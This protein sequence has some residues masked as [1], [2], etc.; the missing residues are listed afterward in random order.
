MGVKID[1]VPHYVMIHDEGLRNAALNLSA[2]SMGPILQALN[3]TTRFMSFVNT[4]AN[5]EFVMGNF[6][7]DIQTAIYNI[8]GEQTMEGGKATLAKGIIS[9]VIRKTPSSI[10]VMYKGLRDP[11]KL[12]GE[13]KKN[14]DEFIGSGAKTDWFHSPAPEEAKANLQNM[15]EMSQGTFK[16]NT[17]AAFGSVL[18][19]VEN[20][21]SAVENGVRFSTFVAARDAMIEKG[22]P[23]SEAIQAAS[24]LAKNLTVNFNRKG[25]AGNLLNGLFLFFN[26]SVQG[27]MNM[28][29]GLNPL[30]PRS[31]RLK[32]GM[33]GGIVGFGA[34]MA[35]IADELLDEEDLEL[36]DAEGYIRDRNMIIPKVLFGVNPEEGKVP[37]WKIPLPYGYNFFHVMGELAYQ[38]ANDNVSPEKAAIRL[39]N[40]GLGSFNPLGTSSSETMFGS[41]AKTI[42]PTIAKPVTEIAM[43]ENYFSSPIY[44]ADSPFGNVADPSMSNRK[45]GGTAEAWRYVTSKVNE[46]AGDGNEYESGWLDVSPDMLKY[47]LTYYTG[48]AG[49]F[50]ERVFMLPSAMKEARELGVDI[51]PNKIP[52]YRRIS[53]EINS[54]PDTEQYYERRETILSKK[55]QA[56]NQQLT[57]PERARYRKENQKYL[58]VI[59]LSKGTEKRLRQLYAARRQISELRKKYPERAVQYAQQEMK[60]QDDIDE[61]INNF[62]KNYDRIV[63][64]TK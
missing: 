58:Q 8:I 53:G 17:R 30:D 54:R 36:E 5:P 43:N 23:V 10:G 52:F 62:N 47:L 49:T 56:E 28:M 33:V 34:L 27:T 41:I 59:P 15:L 48:G 6:P 40:V 55:A 9:K 4:S 21:N 50:A 61:V 18:N 19:F 14:F 44:P 32:Q 26:A 25:N 46:L 45:F 35:M 57:S 24:T 64:K 29:R 37:Y 51:D 20:Y 13:D 1:G 3:S 31:S 11:S 38:V 16:G 39:A 42:T 60:I 7:R 22:V 12:T 63:G 2:E